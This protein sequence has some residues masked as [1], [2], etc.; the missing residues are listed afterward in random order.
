MRSKGADIVLTH[1]QFKTLKNN[2]ISKKWKVSFFHQGKLCE[3][4]YL[5][6][7]TIEWENKPSVEQLEKVEMQVHDLML[8]HIYEDH[9]PNQ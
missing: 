1:F 9:D 8:Y 3:G 4:I 7:G 5:Q 2:W 6:D